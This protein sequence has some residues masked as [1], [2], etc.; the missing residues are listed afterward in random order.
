MALGHSAILSGLPL[1]SA[2][3]SCLFAG[4]L[5]PPAARRWGI[6]RARKVF[7]YAAYG[8]AALFLLLFT[9]IRDASLA[10]IVMSLSSFVVELS[11]PVTWTTAMDLGGESVG[12]LTGMMNTLGHLGQ[13]RAR[14]HWLAIAGCVRQQLEYRV[15]CLCRSLRVGRSLLGDDR[16]SHAARSANHSLR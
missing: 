5:L 9:S 8:G 1:L 6:V 11:A 4:Y 3:C 10:M 2:G 7:A 13:H 15:L 16:S 12:L 14:N